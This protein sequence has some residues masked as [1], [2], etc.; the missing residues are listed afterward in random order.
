[1]SV[2]VNNE[3]TVKEIKEIIPFSD[4]IKKKIL[5]IKP[6]QEGEKL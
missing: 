6:N 1:V 2:K 3:L 4:G 5:E